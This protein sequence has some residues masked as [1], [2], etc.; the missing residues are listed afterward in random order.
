M[1]I[2]LFQ[3]HRFGVVWLQCNYGVPKIFLDVRRRQI[4]ILKKK[5]KKMK[6]WSGMLSIPFV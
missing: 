1:F 3:C 6:N 5:K 2:F 4:C